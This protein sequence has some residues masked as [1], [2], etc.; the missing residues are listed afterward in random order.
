MRKIKVERN[1]NILAIGDDPQLIVDLKEQ[2]NY[3]KAQDRTIPYYREVAFSEDLLSGKRKEVFETAVNFYYRQAC[4]VAEG[5]KA[6]E[7]YRLK[8]NTSVR[9][10]K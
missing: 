7:Q 8:A 5:M 3:I 9:E 6:A 2:K 4:N 1:G 10:V